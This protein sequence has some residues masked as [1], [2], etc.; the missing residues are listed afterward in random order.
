VYNRDP[1]SAVTVLVEN[2]DGRLALATSYHATLV[3]SPARNRHHAYWAAAVLVEQRLQHREILLHMAR[4][5]GIGQAHDLLDH[6]AVGQPKGGNAPKK[7]SS[8]NPLPHDASRSP[9][10]IH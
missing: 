3:R 9:S 7:K 1:V 6:G 8:T 2:R 5:M 10:G 4:R